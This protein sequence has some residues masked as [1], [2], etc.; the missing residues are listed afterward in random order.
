[1]LKSHVDAI[2]SLSSFEAELRIFFIASTKFG[3]FSRFELFPVHHPVSTGFSDFP[4]ELAG[5]CGHR[6][7]SF[8][9]IKSFE[10]SDCL[11]LAT[12][13]SMSQAVQTIE[14]D[15]KMLNTFS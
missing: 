9:E 8:S 15:R 2:C 5:Q 12:L 13:I 6:R 4:L 1:M 3:S 14:E 7:Q 11:F 10:F